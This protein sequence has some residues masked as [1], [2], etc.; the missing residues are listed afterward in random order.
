MS[1]TTRLL[2]VV[3]LVS[4]GCDPAETDPP[5]SGADAAVA[6]GTDAGPPPPTPDGSVDA[7]VDAGSDGGGPPPPG[8]AGCTGD[9]PLELLRRDG[10]FEVTT[11]GEVE[12]HRFG[13]AGTE[14]A[15]IVV[16]YD[17][18]VGDW[19]RDLFDRTVPLNHITF[20]LSRVA[21]V[22]RERYILGMA[23]Q[24]TPTSPSL[25]RRTI[26]F[27]RVDLE[28]R[29]AG[30]GFMAY[31]SFR[32]DF[33]W[34]PMSSYHV[35]VTLDAVAATQVLE[36]SEGGAPV[37]T[38]RGDIPYMNPALTSSRWT[39]ELGGPETDGREV[40]PVG[41]RLCDTTVTGTLAP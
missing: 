4:L 2:L 27:G 16:N 37:Q 7:G 23:P 10:C 13:A 3:A 17:L 20:G 36:I 9:C 21:P 15:T 18:E 24:V 31:Q 40:S 11:A 32:G 33:A 29:P 6:P 12:E 35:Q 1:P 39:L 38:V 5:D 28:E 25:S 30:M 34:R 41:W 19:R 22:S 8:D 26:F 14:Y